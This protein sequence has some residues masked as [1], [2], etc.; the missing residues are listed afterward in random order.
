MKTIKLTLI[1]ANVLN[2]FVLNESQMYFVW[3][4]ILALRGEVIPR[5]IKECPEYIRPKERLSKENSNQFRLRLE[6]PT[7]KR[8]E[9]I[10]WWT[11]L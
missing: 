1:E 10:V 8:L 5:N 7:S 6:S 3:C 9:A 11:G 2:G 4:G